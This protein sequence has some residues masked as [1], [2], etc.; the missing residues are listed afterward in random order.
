MQYVNL[1]KVITDIFNNHDNRIN[2]IHL[3]T[4]MIRSHTRPIIDVRYQALKPVSLQAILLSPNYDVNFDTYT[5]TYRHRIRQHGVSGYSC[6]LIIPCSAPLHEIKDTT[7]LY[8]HKD[9]VIYPDIKNILKHYIG[10]FSSIHFEYLTDDMRLEGFKHFHTQDICALFNI[11][12]EQLNITRKT[13][14]SDLTKTLS[15]ERL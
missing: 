9:D 12:K 10:Y 1:L 11:T 4:L 7:G 8:I 5:I 6:D 3:S 14:I 2:P 15:K 13:T